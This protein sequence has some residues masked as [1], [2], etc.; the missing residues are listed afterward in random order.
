MST[1]MPKIV[2]MAGLS[3]YLSIAVFNNM[4]DRG[5]NKFLLGQMLSMDLLMCDHVLARGLMARAIKSIN[6]STFV[7]NLIIVL[8]ALIAILLWGGTLQLVWAFTIDQD[9]LHLAIN[10]CNLALSLFMGLWFL[11]WC[12]G[13]WFGYWIKTGQIQEVHMK[14]IIISILELLFINCAI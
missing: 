1:L 8:Q 10:T 7:L 6:A 13:L 14:L 4:I 11:F 9:M 2:S 3:C 5:T 12:G